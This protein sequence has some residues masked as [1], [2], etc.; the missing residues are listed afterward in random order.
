MCWELNLTNVKPHTLEI[1]VAQLLRRGDW[2]FG[3]EA[4]HQ[5]TLS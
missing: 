2:M 3:K 5:F 1:S 4:L